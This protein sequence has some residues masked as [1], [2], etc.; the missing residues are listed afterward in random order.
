MDTS[1]KQR[2]DCLH[3]SL[4]T[5]HT[6]HSQWQASFTLEK[7]SCFVEVSVILHKFPNSLGKLSMHKQCVPGSLFSAHAREPE[8]EAI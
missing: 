5:V 4:I 2:T 6:Q 7:L 1:C 8:N 3:C